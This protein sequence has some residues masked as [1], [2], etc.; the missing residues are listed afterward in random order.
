MTPT[1]SRSFIR[2]VRDRDDIAVL[3]CRKSEVIFLSRADHVS[4]GQLNEKESNRQTVLYSTDDG[5]RESYDIRPEFLVSDR[6]DHARVKAF[7]GLIEGRTWMDVGTGNG[8]ILPLL[9]PQASETLAV[10]PVRSYRNALAREGYDVY[11][12][13]DEVRRNDVEVATLFHVL[14]HIKDP[15]ETLARVRAAMKGGGD[16]VIEVPHARDPLMTLYDLP[17]FRN[18]TFWSQHLILY[19]RACLERVIKT[20]GFSDIRVEGRQ[21]YPLANH[22]YWLRHHKPGGHN[23]WGKITTPELEA[24]YEAMLAACDRTDTLIALARA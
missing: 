9:A 6:D 11:S 23:V 22:L 3:R 18:F 24:A 21:R 16:L 19:T 17:A 4:L 10:E 5:C 15:I 12:T 8:G 2:G 7:R 20:A 14:E 13:V 1:P